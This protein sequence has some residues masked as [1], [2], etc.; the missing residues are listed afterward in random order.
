MKE[1][2]LNK[3]EQLLAKQVDLELAVLVG[4]QAKGCA[5]LDSDWDIAIR[6]VK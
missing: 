3:L 5:T 1:L 4:S 2:L 6:W